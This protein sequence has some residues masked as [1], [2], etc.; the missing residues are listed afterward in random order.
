MLD[1]VNDFVL[2][3]SNLPEEYLLLRPAERID[4]IATKF[5]HDCRNFVVLPTAQS[6]APTVV[7]GKVFEIQGSSYCSFSER[8]SMIV[9]LNKVDVIIGSSNLHVHWGLIRSLVIFLG[10]GDFYYFGQPHS[11]FALQHSGVVTQSKFEIEQ[12]S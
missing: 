9:E 2:R 7:T 10:R 3:F 8:G 4:Y 6:V 1:T 5:I 11:T 12:T